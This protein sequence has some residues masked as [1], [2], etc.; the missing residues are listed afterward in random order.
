MINTAS[1][2]AKESAEEKARDLRKKKDEPK[3]KYE[4]INMEQ[5]GRSL[6]FF[7]GD[8]RRP[9]KFSFH[10]NQV[11]EVREEIAEHV[12]SRQTPIWKWV[13]SVSYDGSPRRV[14]KIV[15]YTPRFYMKRVK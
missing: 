10:H 9:E 3:L 8:A 11:V 13:D 7:Y 14:A 1:I 2:D 12:Q 5:P 4:F 6:S 15:G